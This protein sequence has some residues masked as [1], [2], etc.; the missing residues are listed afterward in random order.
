MALHARGGTF[1][2]G[3]ASYR[4]RPVQTAPRPVLARSA[5]LPDGAQVG[6]PRLSPFTVGSD[7]R[8]GV[9]WS[10]ANGA[11]LNSAENLRLGLV[12][13]DAER[14]VD[15]GF[16]V[17]P[18]FSGTSGAIAGPDGTVYLAGSEARDLLSDGPTQGVLT[19]RKKAA[20]SP[21]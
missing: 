5:L 15:S 21:G 6:N 12:R 1:E 19:S 10:S 9:L 14:N 2:V 13:S 16:V 20:A 4:G 18:L 3:A 17:G 8:G 11:T 7:G